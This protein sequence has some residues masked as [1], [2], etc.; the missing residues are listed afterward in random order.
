MRFL[1][2]FVAVLAWQGFANVCASPVKNNN[3]ELEIVNQRGYETDVF[4]DTSEIVS[5]GVYTVVQGID[6][7]YHVV[8]GSSASASSSSSGNAGEC[9]EI[10]PIF[11]RNVFYHYV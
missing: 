3:I 9:V 8:S 5:G 7:S 6:G 10:S 4:L 1:A 11:M 2:I